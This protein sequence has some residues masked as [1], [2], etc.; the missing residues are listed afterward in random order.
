[1]KFFKKGLTLSADQGLYC[2]YDHL[3]QEL[4]MRLCKRSGKERLT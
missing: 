4:Y 3:E 1:M 2:S